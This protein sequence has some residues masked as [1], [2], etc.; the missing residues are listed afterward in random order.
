[1]L[2]G[3]MRVNVTKKC[4]RGKIALCTK[5]FSFEYLIPEGS[6]HNLD[7]PLRA[8]SFYDGSKEAMSGENGKGWGASI[9]HEP[10]G[11][12]ISEK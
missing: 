7:S 8:I 2:F 5:I 12:M 11:R 10:S 9:S 3:K 1:M 6:F 4:L